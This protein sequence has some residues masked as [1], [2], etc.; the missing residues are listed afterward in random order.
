VTEAPEDL[1]A[2]ARGA[3]AAQILL[4]YTPEGPAR[5]LLRPRLAGADLPVVPVLRAHDAAAWPH[6]KA[7]FFKFKEKIPTMIAARQ[8][9]SIAS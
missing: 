8:G 3:G 1:G 4:P 6:A 5:D 2:W 9:L 7:G